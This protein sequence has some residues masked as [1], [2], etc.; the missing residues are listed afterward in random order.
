MKTIGDAY[1]AVC[2]LPDECADHAERMCDFG[3]GMLD[4]LDK[5][6]K[7]HP[8]WQRVQIRVGVHTG[9]LWGGI[10]GSSS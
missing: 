4:I 7:R 3:N 9:E 8:E 6:N 10:L 1:W 2:G 5:Q